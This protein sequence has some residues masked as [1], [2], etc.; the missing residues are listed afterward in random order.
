[1]TLNFL[2]RGSLFAAF[3]AIFLSGVS[4]AQSVEDKLATYEQNLMKI[5]DEKGFKLTKIT[6]KERALG[7]GGEEFKKLD[8]L[9]IALTY[10]AIGAC[11]DDCSGLG[12]SIE[13]S[14]FLDDSSKTVVE[15][16]SGKTAPSVEFFLNP[17]GDFA[18]KI[19]MLSCSTLICDYG[20]DIYQVDNVR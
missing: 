17:F 8:D 3:T 9:P 16:M 19:S 6:R 2:K 7:E 20:V 18:L 4:V 5:A 13:Q 1:M 11:D 10:L 12:L 15:D 14:V